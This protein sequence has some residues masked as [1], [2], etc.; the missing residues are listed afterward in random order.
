[1]TE[2]VQSASAKKHS[3]ISSTLVHGSQTANKSVILKYVT[4]IE[5]TE[6]EVIACSSLWTYLY[7]RLKKSILVQHSC[8]TFHG[9]TAVQIILKVI[10][11][12]IKCSFLTND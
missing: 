4:E 10:F 5:V 12:N 6:T 11:V 7:D 9:F 3:T 1:M 8:A 2:L